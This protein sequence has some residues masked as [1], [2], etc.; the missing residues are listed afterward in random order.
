MEIK[1]SQN[2]QKVIESS[3]TAEVAREMTSGKEWESYYGQSGNQVASVP[4]AKAIAQRTKEALGD[5][6]EYDIAIVHKRPEVSGAHADPI[7]EPQ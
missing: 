2:K 4:I 5:R 3:D 6:S 7:G 1:S